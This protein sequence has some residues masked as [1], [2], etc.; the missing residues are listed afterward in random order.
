MSQPLF[1]FAWTLCKKRSPWTLKGS[2]IW[3]T[4]HAVLHVKQISMV[5]L[6]PPFEKSGHT[7]RSQPR[8]WLVPRDG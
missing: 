4:P 5:G 1:D 7:P 8:V 6:T 3:G 2:D